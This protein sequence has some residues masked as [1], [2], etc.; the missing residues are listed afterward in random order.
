MPD[1]DTAANT[2]R[3]T[4]ATN[5]A[6]L[7]PAYTAFYDNQHGTPPNDETWMRLTVLDGTASM[8]GFGAGNRYRFPGVA[9]VQIFVPVGQGDG[10]ARQLAGIVSDW[11]RGKRLSNVRFFDP[12]YLRQVGPDG[13]W[14]QAN[15]IVPFDYDDTD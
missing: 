3:S 1:F 9:T 5:L 14:W 10:L 7:S 15:L 12:P 4:F 8:V 2:I 11:F 6:G 13:A